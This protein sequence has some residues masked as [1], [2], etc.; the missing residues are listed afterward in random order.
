MTA[1]PDRRGDTAEAVAF[2][3]WALPRLYL[4]WRGFRRVRR[5]VV[6]RIRKRIAALALADLDACRAYLVAE[7]LPGDP[8]PGTDTTFVGFDRSLLNDR[9][10]VAFREFIDTTDDPFSPLDTGIWVDRGAR[11]R[12]G[13]GR[14]RPGPGRVR[15]DLPRRR[16]VPRGERPLPRGRRLG[17]RRRALAPR[18]WHS[19]RRH[20]PQRAGR[21][22][23]AAVP[24]PGFADVGGSG[25]DVRAIES[26][27][28]ALSGTSAAGD[29]ALRLAS[30]TA[31]AASTR[32][33]SRPAA[34]AAATTGGS[35]ARAPSTAARRRSRA[36][37][38][39]TTTATA[40]S[41]VTTRTALPS[42]SVPAPAAATPGRRARRTRT[43][44]PGSPASAAAATVLAAD[45]PSPH[46]PAGAS[47]AA[48]AR[49]A[50]RRAAPRG[51]DRPAGR[52]TSRSVA[53]KPPAAARTRCRRSRSAASTLPS[54]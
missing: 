40:R 36:P 20:L 18:R 48:V 11:H 1:L 34:T 12:A 13:R 42:R 53:R 44:A 14:E 28:F 45:R 2:L 16:R 19:G 5:Q 22:L 3:E 38:A 25:S 39:S 8:A 43:A 10:D 26:L 32:P 17:Q 35:R 29:K 41:T 47:A 52:R 15:R 49:T 33:A 30:P 37:T 23:G 9:G 27:D 7:A 50:D 54:R 21:H 24:H 6:R 4:R 46:R 31:P 51:P